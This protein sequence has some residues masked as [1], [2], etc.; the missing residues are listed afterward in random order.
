MKYSL[1]KNPHTLK[2]SF[3]PDSIRHTSVANT[4]VSLMRNQRC[5]FVSHISGLSKTRRNVL[6]RFRHTAILTP[7]RGRFK[8]GWSSH[9]LPSVRHDWANN[10]N[11]RPAAAGNWA[12]SVPVGR[13]SESGGSIVLREWHVCFLNQWKRNSCQGSEAENYC[14]KMAAWEREKDEDR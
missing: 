5:S 8:V 14:R 2:A 4:H 11:N 3:N 7:R 6:L 12:L 9:Q 1:K 13:T 10:L